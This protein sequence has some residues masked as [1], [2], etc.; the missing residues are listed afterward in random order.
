MSCPNPWM[1]DLL[2]PLLRTPEEENPAEEGAPEE[3]PPGTPPLSGS[4]SISGTYRIGQTLTAVT[5]GITG[6]NGAFSYQW[7]IS[8]VNTG[9]NS[10]SYT[11]T[12][13]DAGKTI[14]CVISRE[15]GSITASGEGVPF[16]LFLDIS[17]MDAG[18]SVS[19]N[20]SAA[21]VDTFALSGNVPIYYTLADT[22]YDSDILILSFVN[23]NDKIIDE[24]DTGV[25]SY[26]VNPQDAFNGLITI[27][28]VSIHTNL[29]ILD[30]PS[31]VTL[32]KAGVISFTAGSNNADAGAVYKYTLYKDE[33]PVTGFIDQSITNGGT[34]SG[35]VNKMLE[36]AGA[37]TAEV[38]AF[39]SNP[40]Y[41]PSSIHHSSP[42]VN[43][44]PLN[45]T[46]TGGNGTNKVTVSSIDYF[47]SFIK[48]VFEGDSVTLTAVPASDRY[49]T[50]TGAGTVTGDDCVVNNISGNVSVTAVFANPVI[51]ITAHP[52]VSTNVRAGSIS[53]S[54]SA[55]ASIVPSGRTL[56]Y[57]W[58][59]N[60]SNSN[61]G[62]AIISGAI[63]ASYTIP[64]NFTVGKYYYFCE[65]RAL[66]ATS[67]RTNVA[68]VTVTDVQPGETLGAWTI[69][70]GTSYAQFYSI[71]V[72]SS[73][74]V[75]A[76]GYQTGTGDYT[77]GNETIKGTSTSS[78][79]ILVKYNSS[80]AALWA[81]TITAG[82]GT[83]SFNSV[84]VDSSGNVYAA[85]SQSTM[86]NYTYGNETIAGNSASSNP[87]LVKYDSSGTALW[88][89]TKTTGSDAVF[90][91]VAV[92]GSGNVYAAG[93]QNGTG[94]YTY[95]NETI[96]GSSSGY[97]PVLVK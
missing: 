1:P 12:G 68:T 46:I 25:Y 80:G 51:T 57:Q 6:G 85:G 32:T 67:V 74:N 81:K 89:R 22:A 96:T 39:T 7:K 18:D 75:Y 42:A 59:S 88:A 20:S 37:Y 55:A 63:S 14:S 94:D 87:I 17:E 5:S 76:V 27:T 35:I 11:I 50:W 56:S 45:V 77:Y 79:P 41:T 54:L 4:A 62:G 91:G 2:D 78:N 52:A 49:V 86:G 47:S 29:I 97:N 66:G 72:D 65:V 23:T 33:N 61:S 82:T 73:G 92:D 34:P 69:T 95:G 43:V 93:R 44:Y 19:F 60:T 53:G 26:T 70:A 13:S 64:V 10:G 83:A 90:L 28:A 15:G 84:A 9:S 24:P 48:N 21:V 71:A 8:G 31:A 40:D 3:N 30:P 16:D 36:S 58:Y 38:A